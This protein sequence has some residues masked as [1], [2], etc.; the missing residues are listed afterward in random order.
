MSNEHGDWVKNYRQYTPQELIAYLDEVIP[1]EKID[2]RY[3][4]IVEIIE[5]IKA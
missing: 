3:S 2:D 1:D 5:G 4:R